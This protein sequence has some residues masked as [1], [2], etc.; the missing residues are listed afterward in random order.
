MVE[1]TATISVCQKKYQKRNK[2]HGCRPL[3]TKSQTKV[4]D[5]ETI[6]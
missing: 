2:K 3:K 4:L 1:P 5:L 6:F